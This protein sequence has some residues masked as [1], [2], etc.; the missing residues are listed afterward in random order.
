MA[1][2]PNYVKKIMKEHK[3]TDR[4]PGFYLYHVLHDDWCN[5]LKGIGV[6]NCNPDI[7]EYEESK[8]AN[9]KNKE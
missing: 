6:C 1:N 7:I 8:R 9:A 3:E 4:G 2:E 5:M